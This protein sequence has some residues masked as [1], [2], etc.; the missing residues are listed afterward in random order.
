LVVLSKVRVRAA[1]KVA[2]VTNL[3]SNSHVKVMAAVT[4]VGMAVVVMGAVEATAVE[5]GTAGADH[6]TAAVAAMEVV[7][8]MADRSKVADTVVAVRA[9]TTQVAMAAA[10]VMGD[11]SSNRD[12]HKVMA[13]VTAATGLECGRD[14]RHDNL[15]MATKVQADLPGRHH[16]DPAIQL[17]TLP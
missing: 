5:A 3:S 16:R 8:D 12:H 10:V 9:M 6:N 13:A 7:A 1:V 4:V 14:L 11:R 15:A 2:A 17:P